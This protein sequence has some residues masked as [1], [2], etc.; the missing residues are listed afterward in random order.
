[1]NKEN[2]K[3]ANELE[4]EIKDLEVLIPYIDACLNKSEDGFNGIQIVLSS[5]GYEKSIYKN[6]FLN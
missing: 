6:S 5:S 3:R 2:I 4:K 1:M